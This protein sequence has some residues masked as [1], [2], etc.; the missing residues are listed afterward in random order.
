MRR[1]RYQDGSLRLRDRSGGKS[2][3]Y[4]WYEMQI[5]G[6]RKRRSTNLG[7]LRE[8]P[9]EAAALKAVSALR[10]NINI[11]TPRAQI[12]A[13]SFDTL[14]EHY[15]MKEMGEDSNKTFATRET[16]EGYLRKWIL[17]RWG[18]VSSEGCEIGSCRGVAQ[19]ASLANGSRAKIRNMMHAD[20]Q[21]RG[22]LGMARSESHHASASKREAHAHSRRFEHRPDAGTAVSAA[23]ASAAQ[24]FSWMYRP[25]CGWGN[26]WPC[27][28]ATLISRTSRSQ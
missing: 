10:A 9:T 16:Y 8:Y 5:D 20:F 26:S 25:D 6:S 28:G 19:V 27:N 1:T 3:E 2:W 17:P 22:P 23:G 14:V 11:E 7:P 24:W 12:K 13:I 4:R 15:R 21:S 18:F